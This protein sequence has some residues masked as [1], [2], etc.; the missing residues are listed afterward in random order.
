MC[1]HHKNTQ[2]APDWGV[3]AYSPNYLCINCLQFLSSISKELKGDKL[4]HR[5]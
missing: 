5:K 4:R 1:V 3:T 2:T